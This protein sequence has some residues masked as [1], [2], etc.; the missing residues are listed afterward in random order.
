MTHDELLEHINKDIDQGGFANACGEWFPARSLFALRAIV[1]LH[2]PQE[3]TLPNG[4][5]GANCEHC[6]IG[7]T[8]P[9]PTI[10]AVKKEL[11]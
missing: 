10:Q 5:W 9:C 3:I 4:D 11:A 7:L 2:K 8:Y 6:D 1:E